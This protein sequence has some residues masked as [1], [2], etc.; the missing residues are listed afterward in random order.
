MKNRILFILLIF[1]L[2]IP[3]VHG[4]LDYTDFNSLMYDSEKILNI[5]VEGDKNGEYQSGSKGQFRQA[6][7]MM[8]LD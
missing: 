5:A 1:P 8:K 6:I 7:D 4:N 3:F 2:Y